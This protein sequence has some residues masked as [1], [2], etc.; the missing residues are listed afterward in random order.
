MCIRDRYKGAGQ[1]TCVVTTNQINFRSSFDVETAFANQFRKRQ[2]LKRIT[3]DSLCSVDKNS[4][5]HLQKLIS[6]MSREDQIPQCDLL[7]FFLLISFQP[8]TI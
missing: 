4:P 6:E 5:P 2:L 1:V 7:T 3:N 8:M